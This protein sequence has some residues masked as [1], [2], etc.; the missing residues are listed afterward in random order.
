MIEA[1]AAEIKILF[2]DVDGVMTD[3]KITITDRGEETKSFDVKDGQGLKMLMAGDVEVVLVTGRSSPIVEQRAR[4][5]G[6]EEV[7]QGITDKGAIC[8]ELTRVKGLKEKE[9]CSMGD[10]LPDLAMFVKAG[11]RIAV[12]DAVKEVRKAADFITTS[13]GGSG[14]VREACE[15][16]LK[17]QKKWHGM[18]AIFSGE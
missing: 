12:A 10:D 7:Y 3:G 16:I 5:L 8:E 1:R 13:K 14:A 2:L 11:L 4:D 9:V 18:T 15:L 17:S 6:I